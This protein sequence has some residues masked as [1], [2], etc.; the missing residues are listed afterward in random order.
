[1]WV[2]LGMQSFIY[3]LRMMAVGFCLVRVVVAGAW[4]VGQTANTPLIL[5]SGVASDAAGNLYVA[6]T[7]KHVVR[8]LTPAGMLTVVA[9]T[10]VQGYM[11]DGAAATNAELDSPQGV[12]VDAAGNLWIADTH[13]HCLRRVDAASGVISTAVKAGL[14]VAVAVSP[15]GAVVF[16]DLGTHQVFRLEVSTGMTTVIAGSGVQGFGGDGGLALGA[17]LDAP[18]ALAFDSAGNLYVADAHNHRVRRVEASTGVI[19]TVVGTGVPG[20]S[21]D[22]GSGTGAQLNLPRGVAFDS[23]GNLYLSDSRNERIRRVDVATGVVNTVAGNGTQGFGGDGSPAPGGMLDSPRG[24]GVGVG[25]LPVFADTNNNRVREVDG[26]GDLQTVAGVGAAAAVPVAPPG[27]QVSSATSLVETNAQTLTATVT[28]ASGVA[29]GAVGLVDGTTQIAS[30]TLTGGT[31][32][33]GT[34]L[35]SNGSHTLTAAYGGSTVYLASVSQPLIMSAGTTA[36]ADFTLAAVAPT[37]I[38]VTAGGTA[39]FGFTVTPVNGTLANPITLSVSGLPVGAVGTLS[40]AM[41]APSPGPNSFELTVATV[42]G[43]AKFRGGLG[44]L[45]LVGLAVVRR[46]RRAIILAGTL[47]LVGCGNRISTDAAIGGTSTVSYNVVV[48]ASST[49]ASG[50]ALVHTATV[51]LT[52]Q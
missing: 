38:G 19:A 15:A 39:N 10:G 21:G 28:G 24:I 40:P 7:G 17:E 51:T 9:G 44:L 4:A 41:V 14:P 31:A 27:G 22:G 12:A 33:F 11:G 32:T 3:L 45:V 29:T 42:K 52:V 30:A 50:V 37:A 16:A 48:T 47:L 36:V 35:L 6:E 2:L 8:R 34:S 26:G 43:A 46:R 25:G 1:M 18:A 13:N 49:T 23:S 20:F 5:P